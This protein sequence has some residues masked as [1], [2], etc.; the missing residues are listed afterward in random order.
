MGPLKYSPLP[1]LLEKSY[2]TEAGQNIQNLFEQK[3]KK[4]KISYVAD[5]PK[6]ISS[7]KG[8]AKERKESPSIV[9][10]S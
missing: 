4:I 7:Q 5:G 8:D 3:Y 1:F 10:Y 2:L 6:G 9:F